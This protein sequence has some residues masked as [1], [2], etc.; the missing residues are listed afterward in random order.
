MLKINVLVIGKTDA[1]WLQQG[2]QVYVDRLKHYVPFSFEVIPDLKQRKSISIPV[3]KQ[4]EAQLILSKLAVTDFVVLLDEKGKNYSSVGLADW[5]EK[6][7]LRTTKLVFVI[8]GPY[9]FDETVY[10]RANTK[11]SLSA[12]T[13]SHQMVRVVILEQLYRAF[14]IIRKEPYHHE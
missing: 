7:S 6:L 3:Q 13:F 2:M 1:S 8:G 5:I 10:A 11:I 9:G 4:K 14:T 12:L